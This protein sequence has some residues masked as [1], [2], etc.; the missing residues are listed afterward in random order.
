VLAAVRNLEQHAEVLYAEPNWI[1]RTSATPNDPR[2]GELWRLN[3]P[4]DADIDAPEAWNVTTGGPGV[5]VAVVDSGVAY[6]H[7]DIA[8]NMW[9]GI[10]FD[11]VEEDPQPYDLNGHGT[12]VA[13]TIGAQ[14]NNLLGVTGVNWDVSLMALRAGNAA[15]GLANADIIQAFNFACANGRIV[16]GS[17]GGSFPSQ[18]TYDTIV[19]PAC[20]NSLF[21]IAAGNGGGDGIGDDNDVS[22]QYPCNYHLPGSYGLGAPNLICVAATHENDALT[23]FSNYGDQSVHLAAPGNN[24]L[25]TWPAQGPVMFEDFETDLAG[26]WNPTG[27]WAR[28]ME[29]RHLGSWSATDSP[30]VPYPANADSSLTRDA[31][32]DLSGQEG[33]DL[34]YWLRLDTE[35][36]FDFF[37]IETSPDGSSWVPLDVWSGSTSGAFLEFTD[38]VSGFD[39]QSL[40]VRLRLTSDALFQF[41]GAHVDDLVVECLAHAGDRRHLDGDPACRRRGGSRARREPCARRCAAEDPIARGR[42]HSPVAQRPRGDIREAQCL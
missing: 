1:Y 2:F 16:N 42:R 25:S 31:P 8:P 5:L 34:A 4:N 32:V 35:F 23:S 17:F 28:T 39:G 29:Q 41:D 19:S 22:R 13:G 40:H 3:Q 6:Q 18:P 26:R 36:D 30:G 11:F 10:G 37:S 15:G 20:A 7:P 38:D 33:C 27:A 14:G 21:V 24:I 9:P 12:H